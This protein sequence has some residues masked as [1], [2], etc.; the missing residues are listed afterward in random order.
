M[1][2]LFGGL[3]YVEVLIDWLEAEVEAIFAWIKEFGGDG[4]MIF[5]LLCGIEEGWFIGEIADFVFAYQVVFEKGDKRVVGVNTLIG[6]VGDQ[7]EILWVLYEVELAQCE[8]LKKWW[9][10]R[11]QVVVDDVLEWMVSAAK[12]D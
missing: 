3:W 7:L 2:D 4:I 5:G 8:V 12:V 9:A 6:D 1:V 11:D 10:E